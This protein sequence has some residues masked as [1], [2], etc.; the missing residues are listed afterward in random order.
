MRSNEQWR[1]GKTAS[2]VAALAGVCLLLALAVFLYSVSRPPNVTTCTRIEVHCVRGALGYFIP[3]AGI[4][5]EDEKGYVRSLDTRTVTDRE[6]IKAFAD[7]IRQGTYQG[8]LAASIP[9]G[10]VD[11]TCYRGN[12]RVAFFTVYHQCLRTGGLRY[13]TYPSGLPDL[14]ILEPGIR[15]LATR[16]RCALYLRDLCRWGL[17][18]TQTPPPYPDPNEW[19]DTIVKVLRE[20]FVTPKGQRTRRHGE[21]QIAGMFRC[22]SRHPSDG[23]GAADGHGDKSKPLNQTVTSRQ[24]DYAMNPNCRLDSPP[25]TVLLFETKPGWNQHGGPEL[26]TLDNHEPRGGL[27]L[28]N[29]GTPQFIRTEGELKQLR[30]K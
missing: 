22:P 17:W 7:S 19:C 8:R 6:L 27:V 10:G 15:P 18:G 26:F 11:V 9:P 4:L 16:W 25:D 3:D 30:W 20:G 21:K 28:L 5:S 2:K 1:L 13:F 24:S 14:T 12:R 29:D 23:L